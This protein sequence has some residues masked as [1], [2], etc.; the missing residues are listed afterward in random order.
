[1]DA[2][3][4]LRDGRVT[5]DTAFTWCELTT[6]DPDIR[7]L[8]VVALDSNAYRYLSDTLVTRA[9]LDAGFG[10]FG[11][12]N[13]VRATATNPAAPATPFDCTRI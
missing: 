11:G 3:N 12:A 10:L 13:E 1:M 8:R 9:G 4:D 6:D 7:L 5:T 2:Q